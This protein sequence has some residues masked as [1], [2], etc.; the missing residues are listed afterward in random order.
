[1]RFF[2]NDSSM[3]GYG[4]DDWLYLCRMD[5]EY[6]ILHL[7]YS[8]E[9]GSAV[10]TCLPILQMDAE[11]IRQSSGEMLRSVYYANWNQNRLI[12]HLHPDDISIIRRIVIPDD[13]RNGRLTDSD[14]YG[15]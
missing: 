14:L 8:G 13:H 1:M 6:R 12:I 10:W 9:Y 2:P 11:Q 7:E 15:N 5:D 4:S 3:S